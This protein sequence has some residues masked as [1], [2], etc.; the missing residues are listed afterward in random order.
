MGYSIFEGTMVDM[1]WL[2]V[3]E[4][5]NQ[6]AVVLLPL[7]VI[8]EHGPHMCLGV[9][10]YLSI[11]QCKV[12]KEMLE[13]RN[14]RAIIAPPF[15]WGINVATGGFP[16]SFSSRKD[17][18]KAIIY[19][20]IESLK[21]SGFD[22]IYGIN[23]HGDPKHCSALIEAF[24]EARQS[25]KVDARYTIP[26]GALQRYGLNGDEEHI[27]IIH[28]SNVSG[29][30]SMYSDIHAGDGET[31][32]MNKY[33]PEL[34]NLEIVGTLRPTNVGDEE[35]STWIEG[36]SNARMITPEGYFGDPAGYDRIDGDYT[37]LAIRISDSIMSLFKE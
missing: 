30:N 16:G 26:E 31:A 25:N 12:V 22:Y 19:D 1:S 18:V 7:G 21:K 32:T 33:F 27:L 34:V 6:R 20:I 13:K 8:E 37:D 23:A 4:Y 5:A 35:L 10:T 28:K 2:E 14:R 15:Y 17:T 29:N 9:D 36:G 24:Y 11:M 3:E